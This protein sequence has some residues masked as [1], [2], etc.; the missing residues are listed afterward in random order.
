MGLITLKYL[1]TMRSPL[2]RFSTQIIS[3]KNTFKE[4]LGDYE[5]KGGTVQAVGKFIAFGL[6]DPFHITTIS[7]LTIYGIGKLMERRT[8]YGLR[9]AYRDIQEMKRS[10]REAIMD[11][12]TMRF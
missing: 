4:I 1:D 2:N 7:G 5:V 9:M 11:I 10:L 8:N 3:M 12:T 6:D